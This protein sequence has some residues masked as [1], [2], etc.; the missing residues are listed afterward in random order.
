MK[1]NFFNQITAASRTPWLGGYLPPADP[2]SL[3]PLSST[4]FIEP[5]P[6]EIPGYA[7]DQT[8]SVSFSQNELSVNFVVV[9]V[10]FL[11]ISY[12]TDKLGSNISYQTFFFLFFPFLF[13]S[14]LAFVS[15]NDTFISPP[16]Q[17]SPVQSCCFLL[18][19][20]SVK[21]LQKF[22]PLFKDTFEWKVKTSLS[23]S[24]LVILSL[25]AKSCITQGVPLKFLY[26]QHDLTRNT[27]RAHLSIFL[28]TDQLNAQILLL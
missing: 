5:P 6:N 20:E 17:C 7:T 1:R 3:C 24:A 12:C 25:G 19:T 27:N 18:L 21:N 15:K 8:S 23:C 22:I 10:S 28:A 16:I 13:F 14:F 11:F 26:F 9:V 2:L 4:E